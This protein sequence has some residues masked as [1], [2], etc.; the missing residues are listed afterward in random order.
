V[1]ATPASD[2]LDDRRSRPGRA[3][4]IVAGGPGFRQY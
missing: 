4:G 3:A 1:P 2:A